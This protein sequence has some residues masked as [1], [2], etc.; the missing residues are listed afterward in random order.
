MRAKLLLAILVF[1]HTLL[2]IAQIRSL[3]ISY[4]EAKLLYF[5]SHPLHYFSQFFIHFFGQN[6]YALRLP[7]IGI[8]LIS[9]FLLYRISFF[10]LTR[11]HDRFWLILVYL[12][13][14]GVTSAALV[15]DL[16]GIKIALTFLFIYGYLRYGKYSYGLLPTYVWL[17]ATFLPLI[18]AVALYEGMEKQYRNALALT[19]LAVFGYWLGGLQIGGT[20]EGRFFDAIGVYAAIFSPIVFIYIFYVL[21]RRFISKE[22]DLVWMIPTVAF[23]LSLLLSFRQKMEIQLFAPFLMAAM[24]LAAQTFLHTYRIRLREFRGRYRWLF[25]TALAILLLNTVAVFFNTYG[26]QWLKKPTHH[27]AYPMHIAKDFATELKKNGIRCID[28]QD[29]EMQLRLHFYG[30]GLCPHVCLSED[31]KKG[32]K[33]VTICYNGKTV[34]KKYVTKISN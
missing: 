24:P 18:I 8:H 2:L 27:F 17:D 26:Y 11:E 32:A 31:R 9:V 1:S 28:A 30:I 14:P 21:Y 7:M 15:V 29:N 19:L 22:R 23:I 10:F 33:K 16:A 34:Y 25:Y 4:N 13:L 3:S 5:S 20:P 12:L 6:D